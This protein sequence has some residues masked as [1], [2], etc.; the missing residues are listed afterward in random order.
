MSNEA[1]QQTNGRGDGSGLPR[2]AVARGNVRKP[3]FEP[4]E[5]R[6]L[7][8]ADALGWQLAGALS[9]AGV[10]GAPA[11][12]DVLT[13]DVIAGDESA[14]ASQYISLPQS[15]AE[16]GGLSDQDLETSL[17]A[18]DQIGTMNVSEGVNDPIGDPQGIYPGRVAWAHDPSATSWDGTGYWWDGNT[19]QGVVSQMMSNALRWL[20]GESTDAG[21]WDALF[22]YQ[23]IKSGKGDVGYTPGEKVVIKGNFNTQRS[24]TDADNDADQTPEVVYALLDQ[25][26]NQAG[27]AQADITIYDSGRYIADKIYNHVAPVFPDVVYAET[28]W[29]NGGGGGDGRVTITESTDPESE[30]VY[31]GGA[32]A[33]Y[34]DNLPQCVVD[35]EYM[36]NMSILKKHE[37][38]GVTGMGKNHFGSLCRSPSHLHNDLACYQSSPD[39]YSP[40]TDL[41]A[42]EQ[43]GGKTVLYM[44][45]G[46]YGGFWSGGDNSIPQKWQMEPFNNHWPSSL[47]LSQDP[48]ALDSVELDFLLAEDGDIKS[49][50][51][52]YLHEAALITDAPSGTTYDPEGDGSPVSASLGV[53]EHWNNATDKYY[54]GGGVG[55]ELY[56]GPDGVAPTVAITT[57]VEND[58]IVEGN[59][60]AI[61]AD[62]SDSDGTVVEVGFYADGDLLFSDTDSSDG[63]GYTWTSPAVGSYV[64]EAQAFDNDGMSAWS[65]SVTVYV[66]VEGDVNRD[67]YID[68][69]DF[70][71][72]SGNWD[73]VASGYT[74]TD[75]D[76]DS[77]GAV[78]NTDFASVLANWTGTSGSAAGTTS[79]ATATTTS[80]ATLEEDSTQ[81]PADDG[82]AAIAAAA[83]DASGDNDS[84]TDGGGSI[85]TA[86]IL[87]GGVSDV[88]PAPANLS[89][90]ER[91][92]SVAHGTVDI[93]SPPQELMPAWR[94]A[95]LTRP[96]EVLDADKASEPLDLL[97]RIDGEV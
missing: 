18:D 30:I 34:T 67:G 75:G 78:G 86:D 4:L 97:E 43:I 76:V 91:A 84:A 49:Y 11:G 96:G 79:E 59:D 82:D 16:E 27:V 3:S 65:D 37:M 61:S 64:L 41:M 10:S 28:D 83:Y 73:P 44:L 95:K 36:V 25:L 33:G 80:A 56:T 15:D 35:A 7:L 1:S 87:G 9:D 32:A 90:P 38:A 53:H 72:V 57:P 12:D 31:S 17:A 46:L 71:L 23:N 39:H 81:S 88:S 89:L 26:V 63:W 74:W 45:D 93:L 51:D 21:A 62:A 60:V 42:H 40:L 5:Q 52:G 19:D 22:R 68:E 6:L 20:T 47:F 14:Y 8:S 48:V 70:D 77:D 29:Y 66:A 54:T 55:I 69:T 50:A 24:H 13:S 2:P 92:S 94:R 58:T 85:E